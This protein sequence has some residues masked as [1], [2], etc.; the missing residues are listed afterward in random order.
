[1]KGEESIT[2]EI[3]ERKLTIK[4]YIY[5]CVCYLSDTIFNGQR[6]SKHITEKDSIFIIYKFNIVKITSMYS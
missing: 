5:Y 3:M 6:A 2:E 1:M 4:T